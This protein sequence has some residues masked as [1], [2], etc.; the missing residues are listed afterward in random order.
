MGRRDPIYLT[1][2]ASHSMPPPSVQVPQNHQQAQQLLLQQQL[3][4][5][6][7][8]EQLHL[9]WQLQQELH[10][11]QQQAHQQQAQ[12]QQQCTQHFG[13]N[14]TLNIGSEIFYRGNAS[15][16]ILKRADLI[17]MQSYVQ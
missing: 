14:T 16:G 8:Q 1:S 6:A 7:Q 5:Q 3:E 13:P 15:H 4:E 11:Q 9:Q 12:Q 2:L 17:P 10:Q